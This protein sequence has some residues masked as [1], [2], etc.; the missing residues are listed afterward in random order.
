MRLY[1]AGAESDAYL[2]LRVKHKVDILMSFA[3]E[4]KVA[5]FLTQYRYPIFLDSGAFSVFKRNE[6][7]DIQQYIA[8][9]KRFQ[10]Q[11]EVYALLDVIGDAA[12]TQRNLDIMEDAG[13][14]PL[15][16]FHGGGSMKVLETL[17]EKYDYIALGGLV[18]L[19]LR[20]K[21]LT[22][23]LDTC[24]ATIKKY[25]PKKIHGFG[26]T[27]EQL[28]K[29]YPFY[30]VDSTS[31]LSAGRFGDAKYKS[32]AANTVQRKTR[33]YLER[34]EHDLVGYR[35]KAEQI[36]RLWEKRGVTWTS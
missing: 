32:K 3:Y 18:P 9:V 22:A 21:V 19:A 17:C 29:R 15:P 13:L 23:W 34:I 20:P 6:Q 35:A 24:F 5:Q 16:V 26:M 11:L 25:W 10:A 7:I 12:G 33:H 30:S 28:W 36:T 8:F 27:N 14:T 4:P 1:F 31:W 2:K